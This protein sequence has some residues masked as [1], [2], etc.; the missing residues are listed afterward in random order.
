M[1]ITLEQRLSELV[2]TEFI[3][4]GDS[5]SYICDDTGERRVGV[6]MTLWLYIT[7]GRETSPNWNDSR[8]MAK[9]YTGTGV[10]YANAAT[11]LKALK[12]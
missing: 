1:A 11:I 9:I 8:V 2:E 7:N 6:Y 3:A 12:G 10:T 4:S 5:I